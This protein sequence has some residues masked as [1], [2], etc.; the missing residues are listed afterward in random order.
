MVFNAE[1]KAVSLLELTYSFKSLY[2][3]F[4]AVVSMTKDIDNTYL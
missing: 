3:D 2:A 1:A 4:Y